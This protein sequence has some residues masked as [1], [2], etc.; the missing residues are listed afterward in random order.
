MFGKKNKTKNKKSGKL[1]SALTTLEYGLLPTVIA[2][3]S[4]LFSALPLKKGGKVSSKNKKSSCGDNR[5][6]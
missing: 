3:A 1:K 6:Y 5:L 4:D 2:D